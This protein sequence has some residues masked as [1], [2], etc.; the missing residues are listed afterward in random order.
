MQGVIIKG[1]GGFYEVQAE[2]AL[3]TCRARGKFRKDGLTPLPGDAVEFTPGSGEELGY[4]DKIL[5]RRNA[6]KR[7]AVANVDALVL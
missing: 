2:G 1:V 7:P 3:Y 6:L 5:P 4:V